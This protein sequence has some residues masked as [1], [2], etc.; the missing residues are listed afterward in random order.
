[1]LFKYF[2]S[3]SFLCNDRIMAEETLEEFHVSMKIPRYVLVNV[4]D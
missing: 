2:F 1:M 4:S 3:S